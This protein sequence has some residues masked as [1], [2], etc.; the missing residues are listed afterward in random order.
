MSASQK[1]IKSQR[2]AFRFQC[3]EHPVVIKTEFEDGTAS[4]V[5]ISTSGAALI[6]TSLVLS[7]NEKVLLTFE[8]FD[9]GSPVEIQA[10]VVRTEENLQSVQFRGVTSNIKG[11]IL[12]FF[13]HKA[14][15]DT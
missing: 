14:R 10:F 3:K 13:A 11:Q 8:L 2:K 9:K 5:N 15:S 12:K 7:K 4:L 6:D 1:I